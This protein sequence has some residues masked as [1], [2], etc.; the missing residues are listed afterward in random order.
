MSKKID[1]ETILEVFFENTKEHHVREIARKYKIH[2]TT[3]SSYLKQIENE[4]LIKKKIAYN[5]IFYKGEVSNPIFKQKK[6]SHNIEKVIKSGLIQ[7]LEESLHPNTIVLFGSYAKGENTQ[8]SDLDVFVATE[9]KKTPILIVFEK[10]LKTKIQIFQMNKKKISY[11]KNTQ[12][13]LL[14]N[15]I[16]GITLS[17]FFEVI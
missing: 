14:N 9:S 6:I 10:M 3:A 8:T 17:G 15:I 1:K 13:H 16:N 7:Y 12:P 11:L 5:H 2:P 4:K